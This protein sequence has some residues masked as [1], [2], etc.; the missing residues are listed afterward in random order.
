VEPL[1]DQVEGDLSDAR[2]R[3]EFVGVMA[4]SSATL[5]SSALSSMVRARTKG[6]AVVVQDFDSGRGVPGNR[7]HASS[8]LEA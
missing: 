7:R 3:P 6:W 5:E 1:P 4:T 2:D 8:A